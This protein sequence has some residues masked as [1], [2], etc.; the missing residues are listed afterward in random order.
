MTTRNSIRF[1]LLGCLMRLAIPVFVEDSHPVKKPARAEKVLFVKIAP[2]QEKTVDRDRALVMGSYW[3]KAEAVQ[4]LSKIDDLKQAIHRI[5]TTNWKV[6]PW[7][8]RNADLTVRQRM[9][10]YI[11]SAEDYY[12]G[13]R[14]IGGVVGSRLDQY[15]DIELGDRQLKSALITVQMAA[16]W[17]IPLQNGQ[18]KHLDK[19]LRK[20][21]ELI[22]RQQK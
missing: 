6:K 5:R 3:L 1:V 10:D 7:T 17:D 16:A 20:R 13:K 18:A 19:V 2:E 21:L 4:E 12:N 15:T 22:H 9:D 8:R 14:L 11:Q